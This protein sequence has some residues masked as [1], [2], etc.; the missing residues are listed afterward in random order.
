M[1]RRLLGFSIAV[2][3]CTGGA[4]AGPVTFTI[5]PVVTFEN[6]KATKAAL[7]WGNVTGTTLVKT[8]V[9]SAT[10]V[11]NTFNVLQGAVLK[12]INDFFGPSCAEATK[13]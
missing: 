5:D 4:V 13:K 7:R 12:E 9:W 6:G 11:D 8:A 1:I 3:A 2:A 10:A